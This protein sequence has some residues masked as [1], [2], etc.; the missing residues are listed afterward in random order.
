MKH[1]SARAMALTVLSETVLIMLK[2][3]QLI[4]NHI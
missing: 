2:S 3:W 1:S 4:T